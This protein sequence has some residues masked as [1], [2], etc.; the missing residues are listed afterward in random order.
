MAMVVCIMRQMSNGQVLPVILILSFMLIGSCTLLVFMNSVSARPETLFLVMFAFLSFFA[1]WAF[2]PFANADGCA[3]YYRAFQIAQGKFFCSQNDVE[4]ASLPSNII[5]TTLNDESALACIQRTWNSFIDFSTSSTY[6]IA[7]MAVYFPLAFLPSAFGIK[8]ATTISSS[9]WLAIYLARFANVICIG[10]ILYLS[11]KHIPYGK[12]LLI[13]CALLPMS[14]DVINSSSPDG[15]TIALCIALLSFVLYHREN[16]RDNTLLS[17][18]QLAIMFSLMTSI[19]LTKIVYL[20]VAFIVFLLPN[21]CFA[22]Q[23]NKFKIL[24]IF[25]GIATLFNLLWLVLAAK[26]AANPD[27]AVIN[28]GE[29]VANVLTHPFGYLMV[30]INTVLTDMENWLVTMVG[31]SLGALNQPIPSGFILFLLGVI[32]IILCFDNDVSGTF[33]KQERTVFSVISLSVFFLI[34]TS[35]YITW[36][37]V[38]ASSIMGVQGRYFLPI[39]LL[40]LLAVKPCKSLINNRGLS[41]NN[42]WIFYFCID[43]CVL[44]TA[45]TYVL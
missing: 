14:L 20:P 25:S 1:I 6:D 24:F 27:P 23:R 9:S 15:L 5:P 36:T 43:T 13:A 7:G 28:S 34:L 41:L 3:H 19:A 42:I 38:K 26:L 31:E 44:A 11:I 22:S 21:R 18:R 8:I 39:L 12:N 37:P 30:C 16:A 35:E 4:T 29:Q 2:P 45:L 32:G 17:W 10:W 40:T 33:G